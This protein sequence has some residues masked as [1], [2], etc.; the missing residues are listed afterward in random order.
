M[1]GKKNL[2]RKK[3]MKSKKQW[4]ILEGIL[5]V[6]ALLVAVGMFQKK[7]GDDQEKISVIVS[8]SDDAQW[9]AFKYGLKMAAEDLKAE[10]FIV[11]VSGNLT[12]G[13]T[14]I[15]INQ[16][17][18]NGADGIVLQPAAGEKIL[19]KLQKKIPVILI[20]DMAGG[21]KSFPIVA[22]EQY[23]L[24]KILGEE[25]AKDYNGIL[26][27]KTLGIFAQKGKSQPIK[28]REKGL[29]DA[30]AGTGVQISWTVSDIE[31]SKIEKTLELQPKVDFVIGLDDDSLT[32][33]GEAAAV[34]NLHGALVYGIGH[35]TEAVYYVDTGS[36]ECLIV[37]DEFQVGY[38]SMSELIKKIRKPFYAMGNR[39]VSYTVLRKDN[40]FLKENQEIL[41]TMSQ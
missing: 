23:Q 8:E 24:G 28:E 32:K 34:N 38:Q 11:N 29:R 14:E 6:L 26:G 25:I 1:P 7:G 31:E 30:L 39:E 35:S 27:G 15:L 20:E 40:L 16:E 3:K 21:G 22:P 4:L 19:R 37:P 36:A 9:S 10:I 41:F 33:A 18:E 2:I 17:I 13:E 12:E 5:A